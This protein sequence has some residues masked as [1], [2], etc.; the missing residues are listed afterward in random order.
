MRSFEGILNSKYCI[1][2]PP[3]VEGQASRLLESTNLSSQTESQRFASANRA[4]F[5]AF[6]ASISA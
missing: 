1:N 4:Y 2:D 5:P 6:L 3:H